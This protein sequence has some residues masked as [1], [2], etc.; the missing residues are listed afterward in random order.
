MADTKKEENNNFNIEIKALVTLLA[1]GAFVKLHR[2]FLEPSSETYWGDQV[3]N[4]LHQILHAFIG[5]AIQIVLLLWVAKFIIVAGKAA[6]KAI[7]DHRR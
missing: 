5:I 3:V 2:K 7:K 1:S 6:F 4:W